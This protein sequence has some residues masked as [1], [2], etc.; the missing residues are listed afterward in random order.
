MNPEQ[1]PQGLS[2]HTGGFS[3]A[4]TCALAVPTDSASP[5]QTQLGRH[6]NSG[7]LLIT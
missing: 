7:P 5:P 1:G 4:A 3:S 6:G 2:V